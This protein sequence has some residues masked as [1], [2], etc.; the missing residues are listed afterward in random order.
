MAF[1]WIKSWFQ[2]RVH[3]VEPVQVISAHADLYRQVYGATGGKAFG[4]LPDFSGV[5]STAGADFIS[6][7]VGGTNLVALPAKAMPDFRMARS[8]M[9]VAT[10]TITR[11]MAK[12]LEESDLVLRPTL[13]S[14][15]SRRAHQSRK[16]SA[17]I[18]CGHPVESAH[19]HTRLRRSN[20]ARNW[21][22]FR[23]LPR[24]SGQFRRNVGTRSEFAQ[25]RSYRR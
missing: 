20:G 21:R 16:D 12:S 14:E 24:Q 9:P 5:S 8:C 23:P 17:E 11:H 19:R 13:C 22:Q 18:F 4:M 25:N 7:K 10:Q 6:G 3:H 1:D 15:R 2:F